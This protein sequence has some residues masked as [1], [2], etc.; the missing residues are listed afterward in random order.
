MF[1][2]NAFDGIEEIRFLEEPSQMYSNRWLTTI[3]LPSYSI[4]EGLREFLLKDNI[5]SR[6]LWKPMHLQPI[7]KDS[8]AFINGISEDLFKKGLCLPSGS[9]LT[10][11]DLNRVTLGIKTYFTKC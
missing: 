6:P 7:F 9:N 1:Y 2:I 3:Q 5:E 11:D 10:E 8:P 4:R